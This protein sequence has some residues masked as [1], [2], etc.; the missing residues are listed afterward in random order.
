MSNILVKMA[1]FVVFTGL[2]VAVS[3]LFE[4]D[5]FKAFVGLLYGWIFGDV[6]DSIF[7]K[8]KQK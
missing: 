7:L 1:V 5:P 6:Y 2:V 4:I 3:G 8:R